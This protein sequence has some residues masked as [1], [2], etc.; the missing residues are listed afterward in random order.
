MLNYFEK[1]N[2]G[3]L[4]I[5]QFL[6]DAITILGSCHLRVQ[7]RVVSTLRV[8]IQIVAEAYDCSLVTES[9]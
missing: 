3:V 8:N 1:K 5:P 4:Q 7:V 2:V 9:P 6:L